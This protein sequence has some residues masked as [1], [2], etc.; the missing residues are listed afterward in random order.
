MVAR[1]TYQQRRPVKRPSKLDPF[2]GQIAAM[3]AIWDG[4]GRPWDGIGTAKT[5]TKPA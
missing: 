4:L 3:L 1:S 2:K 5:L